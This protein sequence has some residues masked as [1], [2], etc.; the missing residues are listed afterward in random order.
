MHLSVYLPDDLGIRL[1]RLAREVGLSNEAVL[2]AL[3]EEYLAGMRSC[4]SSLEDA[5]ALW[6]SPEVAK[7]MLRA[8]DEIFGKTFRLDRKAL[9]V[10]PG[11]S[12]EPSPPVS[13]YEVL[14]RLAGHA[15]LKGSL[16]VGQELGERALGLYL[17][18]F[19][20]YVQSVGGSVRVRQEDA[21]QALGR[22]WRSIAAYVVLL[23]AG[24]GAGEE[25]LQDKVRFAVD[26]SDPGRFVSLVGRR[27][28]E[29][30]DGSTEGGE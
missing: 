19:S 12:E 27:K 13:I 3:T 6:R 15:P 21:Q 8:A 23:K 29:G 17:S 26:P 28:G 7:A 10:V 5:F 20:D 25:R 14:E 11:E 24:S 22:T 4:P 16:S 9:V 1:E 30:E 2:A 18:D